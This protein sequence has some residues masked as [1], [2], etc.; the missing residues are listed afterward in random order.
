MEILEYYAS[1]S[2]FTDPGKNAGMYEGLPTDAQSI[3]KTVDGICLDFNERWKYPIQ[4]ERWLEMNNRYVDENLDSVKALNKTAKITEERPADQKMMASV[5]HMASICV[6]MLRHVGIPARKRIGYVDDGNE[7][8]TYEIVEYYDKAEDSWKVLDPNGKCT[9][10]IP[11]AQAFFD[12]KNGKSDEKK[13]VLTTKTPATDEDRKAKAMLALDT[14]A[15]DANRVKF[16]SSLFD[17][18]GAKA[19]KVT[20]TETFA[21][22]F[23][24]VFGIEEYPVEVR[25]LAVI[26]PGSIKADVL[27]VVK[28]IY[29][30]SP[31]YY[32]EDLAWD[33]INGEY[34]KLNKNPKGRDYIDVDK[35]SINA[36]DPETFYTTTE[37]EERIKMLNLDYFNAKVDI[38]K[39][40]VR[41]APYLDTFEGKQIASYKDRE[42][43]QEAKPPKEY[44]FCAAPITVTGNPSSKLYSLVWDLDNT[45]ID[46]FFRL[47]RYGERLQAMY[48]D[49]PNKE[50]GQNIWKT[51]DGTLVPHSAHVR[52][53]VLN[54]TDENLGDRVASPLYVRFESEPV[55][56][57]EEGSTDRKHVTVVQPITI[58][59]T[60]KNPTPLI[61]AYEGPSRLRSAETDVPYVNPGL[62][63]RLVS[64][65]EDH[66]NL[67]LTSVT[68]S[69]PVTINLDHDFRGVIY[70]P[71]SKAII[72]GSG[73]IE[74]F[75]L[76][77]EIE[78]VGSSGSGRTQETLKDFVLPVLM[79]DGMVEGTGNHV[80]KSY[81]ISTEVD[82]YYVVY[83][84][85]NKFNTFST[86]S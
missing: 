65:V 78:F 41:A 55:L 51:A 20:L 17:G 70:V 71:F 52:A 40:Y 80:V 73:K 63:T 48:V 43:A 5:S 28:N 7:F 44:E 42:S 15:M 37:T 86:G 58:N 66:S 35:I 32:W 83:N 76:A 57:Y 4:N 2:S 8:A 33:T 29:D 81:K 49:R 18:D 22:S 11:A 3:C 75:I 13:Y 56:I 79:P 25:A 64:P 1:Q 61:I 9:G 47:K 60:G 31:N 54:I 69:P 16:A 50:A 67:K 26:V 74:G 38:R 14:N 82:N 84:K 27:E 59:V 85:F 34:K 23:L 77:H 39:D 72:K 45:L 62:P 21:T 53:T 19:Y 6:S 30:I 46:N 12:V 36:D 68:E 24:K 10:F